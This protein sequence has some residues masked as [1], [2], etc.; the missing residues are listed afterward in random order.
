MEN[1]TW[2]SASN[3]KDMLEDRRFEGSFD[4]ST[5]RF[6]LKLDQQQHEATTTIT[7]SR[8]TCLSGINACRGRSSQA[9]TAYPLGA[10]V[11]VVA[12]PPGTPAAIIGPKPCCNQV[13]LSRDVRADSLSQP[14]VTQNQCCWVGLFECLLSELIDSM[15]RSIS[16]PLADSR[17]IALIWLRF[18]DHALRSHFVNQVQGHMGNIL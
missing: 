1:N 12:Y 9:R 3:I 8:A 11:I 13:E 5:T 7:P 2:C 10:P 16:G 14:L 4:S 15:F 6:Q 18:A 17:S